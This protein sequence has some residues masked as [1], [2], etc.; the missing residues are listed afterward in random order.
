MLREI[1]YHSFLCLL[2][3]GK[4]TLTSIDID[5]G[6]LDFQK[7]NFCKAPDNHTFIHNHWKIYN[8]ELI[9]KEECFSTH[10]HD[11]HKNV[12][13]ILGDFA[14][15]IIM[16]KIKN[17]SLDVILL[18]D[19]IQFVS[20]INIRSNILRSLDKKLKKGGILF[21]KAP[22]QYHYSFNINTEVLENP[23]FNNYNAIMATSLLKEANGSQ[24]DD[25][26]NVIILQKK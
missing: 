3:A 5:K 21:I 1:L 16:H 25:L 22:T 18:M 11:A 9:T 20:S 26:L 17:N 8:A 7:N 15:D 6:H 12:K 23:I 2:G 13:Y 4:L 19:S 10:C 24:R 14:Q